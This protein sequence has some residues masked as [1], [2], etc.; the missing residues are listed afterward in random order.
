MEDTKRHELFGGAITAV[1]PSNL[2]DASDIRPVPD[3]QEVFLYPTGNGNSIIVESLMR[4]DEEDPKKAIRFIFLGSAEDTDALGPR[5]ELVSDPIH[6]GLE[7][8]STPSPVILHGTQTV[9]KSRSRPPER[10]LILMAL[11]RLEHKRT[12]LLVTF[13]IPLD[14][15]DG[16]TSQATIDATKLQFDCFTRSLRIVDFGLFA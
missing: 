12:D 16:A 9:I 1:G 2:V 5:V 13:N 10:V 6:A 7:D 3:A 4:V 11:Y 14:G 15:P 8:S